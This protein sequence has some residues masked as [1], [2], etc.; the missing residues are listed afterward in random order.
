[1]FYINRKDLKILNT[2]GKLYLIIILMFL[3][4]S[5]YTQDDVPSKKEATE[6]EDKKTD[7]IFPGD[8]KSPMKGNIHPEFMKS[9]FI[10]P[11]QGKAIKTTNLYWLDTMKVGFHLKPRY[12]SKQN[13]DFNKTTDDYTSYAAQTS[14]VWFIVDPSPYF[15]I[16]VTIQ[17]A[18]VWGGSQAPDVGENRFGLA[19]NAGTGAPKIAKNNTDIREAFIMIKKQINFLLIFK[20]EDRSLLLEIFE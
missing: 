1:N 14:Q 4:T 7:N 5:L 3:S 15:A 19:T 9:M 18:R 8:Y 10:T 6:N 20:S 16:K 13:F 12:E 2:I 11:A 17:D